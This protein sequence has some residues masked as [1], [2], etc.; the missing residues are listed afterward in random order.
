MTFLVDS[1]CQEYRQIPHDPVMADPL[2]LGIEEQV[3]V[4][5]RQHPIPELRELVVEELGYIRDM[6]RADL[7]SAKALRDGSHLPG[8]HALGVHLGQREFESHLA[9]ATPLKCLRIERGVSH[10]GNLKIQRSGPRQ[11]CLCLEAVG[12]PLS[13]R[14][15]LIAAS[16]Q[17]LFSLDLH[18]FIQKGLK[19][20]LKAVY[21]LLNEHFHYS[22]QKTIFRIRGQVHFF[23]PFLVERTKKTDPEL[24][25]QY[26]LCNS[27]LASGFYRRGFTPPAGSQIGA[28]RK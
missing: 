16:V 17:M 27:S 7:G 22:S 19:H 1:D 28:E 8:T 21:S 24:F 15:P 26:A 3:R 14:G 11:Q 13:L 4:R 6:G 9:S 2:V 23:I 5:V 18:G 25:N 10:L 20:R 12:V